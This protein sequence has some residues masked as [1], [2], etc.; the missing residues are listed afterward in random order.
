MSEDEPELPKHVYIFHTDI[1]TLSGA[2]IISTSEVK[3]TCVLMK[4]TYKKSLWSIPQ[5]IFTGNSVG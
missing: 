2:R 5:R 4:N 1:C 3:Y